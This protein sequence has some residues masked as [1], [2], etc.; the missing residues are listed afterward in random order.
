MTPRH[1]APRAPLSVRL[2]L[3]VPESAHTA[4]GHRVVALAVILATMAAL[5]GCGSAS[6]AYPDPA[7]RIQL[8]P[9]PAPATVR[10][11]KLIGGCS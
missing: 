4:A 9:E 2:A 6:A 11:S 3:R 7:P 1:R 5:V 8:T 10:P